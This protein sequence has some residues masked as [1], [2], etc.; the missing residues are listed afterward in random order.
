MADEKA[1]ILLTQLGMIS[2]RARSGVHTFVIAC[3]IN[4]TPPLRPAPVPHLFALAFH[5]IIDM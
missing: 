5:N 1:Y 4:I 2:S 3:T